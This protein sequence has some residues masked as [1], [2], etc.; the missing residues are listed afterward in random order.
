MGYTVTRSTVSLGDLLCFFVIG[1]I[2]FI[3]VNYYSIKSQELVGVVMALLYITT[4]IAIVLNSIPSLTIASVSHR[5]IKR[6]LQDMPQ[7][8]AEDKLIE[9][10]N[11]GSLRFE[12]IS[13]QYSAK[14]ADEI[15]FSV[16]PLN[17]EIKRGEVTF[18]VG[19]NGSGKSTLSKLITQH[20]R[21]S[22]GKI[23]FG[24]Q[25]VSDSN[26]TSFRN[27]IYAIYSSFYLFEQ[28]LMELD[29]DTEALIKH[30]LKEFRLDKKVTIEN[31]VFS[32]TQLSDGQR[33]R[34]ALLVGFLDDK[35]LYLF[36]EWAADQDP[37]F[38][39]VFYTE[40]L[41][42][43]RAKNKAVVVISHDDKYFGCADKILKMNN[44]QLHHLERDKYASL[45]VAKL[46]QPN[47]PEFL[48]FNSQVS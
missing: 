9:I 12:E 23:Y 34:L 15:A 25:E 31:G 39:N 43:L 38:K 8:T 36:D 13:Y 20:Y 33:K 14:S 1:S 22:N 48:P 11:W 40:I 30:Y 45:N 18:I 32:T 42:E 7:E 29:T 6:L 47:N 27:D 37:D 35:G 21:P 10:P 2:T 41:P 3:S 46:N 24:E 44:G 4:P 16:G 28:L 17:L 5:K 19:G 26:I